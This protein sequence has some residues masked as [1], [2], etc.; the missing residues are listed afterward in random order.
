[1]M[2]PSPCLKVDSIFM[3]I[4]KVQ[5]CFCGQPYRIGLVDAKW[6]KLMALFYLTVQKRSVVKLF[7]FSELLNQYGEV[8]V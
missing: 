2:L 3:H 8:C 5:K 1:M 7:V 4:L 6:L